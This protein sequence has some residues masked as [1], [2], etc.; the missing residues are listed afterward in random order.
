M[1]SAPGRMPARWLLVPLVLAAVALLHLAFGVGG[2][3][4]LVLAPL[5]VVLATW[6]A[7]RGPGVGA[8]V[9]AGALGS[10]LLSDDA[11]SRGAVPILL[12]VHVGQLVITALVAAWMRDAVRAAHEARHE[13]QSATRERE[14][15]LAIATHELRT[16]LTSLAAY[17]RL[18]AARLHTDAPGAAEANAMVV[19]EA[20]QAA[21]LITRLLESTAARRGSIALEREVVDMRTVAR[22]ALGTV[23]PSAEGRH[24]LL[25]MLDV[26]A[27]V[28][29]DPT[30]LE[31]LLVNLLENAVKYSPDGTPIEV[32]VTIEDS[33]VVARV[34]DEGPGIAPT[35]R[36]NVFARFYRGPRGRSV[37]LGVGLYLAREIARAHGG[38]LAIEATGA[39]GSTFALRLPRAVDEEIAVDPRSDHDARTPCRVL[40][41][42][43][44]EGV[45]E[46]VQ[47]LL[48]FAGHECRAA[49]TSAAALA[50][51]EA[52]RPDVILLDQLRASD[53]NFASAY[54]S[55]PGPHAA[56]VAFS[57]ASDEDVWA[58]SIAAVA[59]IR[60]PFD[61]EDLLATIQR[62]AANAAR[63]GCEGGRIAS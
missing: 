9:A 30:R 62:V 19:H 51:A 60:K 11:L 6:Y 43:D 8:A 56:I 34:R 4:S 54:R 7:G 12:G 29:G 3:A 18:V 1:R 25:S 10:L 50:L 45:R 13:A 53:P 23:G 41:V 20:Q 44:D 48:A 14:E 2:Q 37:G 57:A 42:D 58:R 59:T 5:G 61:A 33:H 16:P 21:R 55:S 15:Q 52:W 39:R 40:L 32:S 38:E 31:E 28:A 36:S 26:S 49:S 17:A 24:E 22:A 47:A 35:E 46:A 27:R 63:P